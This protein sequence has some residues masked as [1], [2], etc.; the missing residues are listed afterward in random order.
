MGVRI[1]P[2]KDFSMADPVFVTW[3][4]N[5]QKLFHFPPKISVY[6]KAG[7]NGIFGFLQL[8]KFRK[9][10]NVGITNACERTQLNEICV[11]NL[12]KNTYRISSEHFQ[13]LFCTFRKPSNSHSE[14][15]FAELECIS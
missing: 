2:R 1:F 3:P 13:F 9:E 7:V 5:F 10:E 6:Q 12:G 4:Y 14:T 15:K 8:Q 11:H